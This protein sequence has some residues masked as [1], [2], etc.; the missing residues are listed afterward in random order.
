MEEPLDLL[1]E[2]AFDGVLGTFKSSG[3]KDDPTIT[4]REIISTIHEEEM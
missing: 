2:E 3:T 1:E 4:H